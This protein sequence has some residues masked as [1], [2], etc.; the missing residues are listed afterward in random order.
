MMVRPAWCTSTA[1]TSNRRSRCSI[2]AKSDEP[3]SL[4][5]RTTVG[6][7]STHVVSDR[8]AVT[9]LEF[10]G[11]LAHQHA[12]PVGRE[13]DRDVVMR[14]IG[15][16]RKTVDAKQRRTDRGVEQTRVTRTR[17]LRGDL[18]LHPID[19][20]TGGGEHLREGGA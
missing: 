16:E 4:R 2:S 15:H 8:Q 5:L 20:D 11:G 18:M 17:D 3:L 6:D 19:E 12:T 14:R 7:L 1:V 10:G 13:Q 9:G